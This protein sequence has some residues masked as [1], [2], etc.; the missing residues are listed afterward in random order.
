MR[1]ANSDGGAHVESGSPSRSANRP[2]VN[3]MYS[4]LVNRR[5]TRACRR[6]DT[7]RSRRP[8]PPSGA[9]RGEPRRE[10]RYW[11]LAKFKSRSNAV[12]RAHAGDDTWREQRRR[13]HTSDGEGALGVSGRRSTETFVRHRAEPT[14]ALR[15]RCVS[16]D[17][18]SLRA[19]GEATTGI[20]RGGGSSSSVSPSFPGL[21]GL[22]RTRRRVSEARLR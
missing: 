4:V 13:E 15:G 11:T 2:E 17:G 7:P 14:H 12:A 22:P 20:R 19:S 21:P 9:G 10:D 1:V 3:T 16:H 6:D 5:N 8:P 18:A